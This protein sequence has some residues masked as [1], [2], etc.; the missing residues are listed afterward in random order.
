MGPND[1]LS[2]LDGLADRADEIAPDL[3]RSPTLPVDIK[4]DPLERLTDRELEIFEQIGRGYKTREIAEK[5]HVSIKTIE[6]H[7]ENIKQKLRLKNATE[8]LQVATQWLHSPTEDSEV[9]D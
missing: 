3:F 4:A 9:E 2:F 7:R 1:W 5:L 8:L 6:A